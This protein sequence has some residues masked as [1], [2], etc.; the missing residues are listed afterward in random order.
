MTEHNQ[1]A[2]CP[3]PP[4]QPI[5][6]TVSRRGRRKREPGASVTPTT[7]AIDES[8]ALFKA[9]GDPTRLRILWMLASC[10][11]ELC[12]C[13]IEAAFDLSQPTISHHLKLL[14]QAGLVRAEKRGLW[15]YYAIVPERVQRARDILSALQPSNLEVASIA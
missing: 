9:I 4:V 5:R 12:V 14:R 15:V 6:S 8:A 13:D 7:A 10:G 3:T 2:C 11:D 1:S